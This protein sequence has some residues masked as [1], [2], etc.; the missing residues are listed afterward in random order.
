MSET[1][2]TP[3]PS[4]ERSTT[5][6]RPKPRPT[7]PLKIHRQIERLENQV[8]KLTKENATLKEKV[9]YLKNAHSRIRKLP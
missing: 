9:A 3:P 4:P 8:K 1:P 2:V 5:P 6:P 7:L